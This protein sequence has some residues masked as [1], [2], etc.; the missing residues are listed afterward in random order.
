VEKLR[1]YY[2]D[3]LDLIC[4]DCRRRYDI[5][6]LR[7]LDCKHDSCQPF[8]AAAPRLIDNLCEPCT[9]HFTQVR[10]LLGELGIAYTIEPLLVRGLDYYART[11][12]E[13][14]PPIESSQSALGGGGRY[15]GLVEQLG[16]PSTPAM[17]FGTGIE[18]IILNLKR[19]EIRPPEMARIDA[20]I[21]VADEAAAGYAMRAARELRDAADATVV[22]GSAGRSLRAQL[23]QAGSLNA[24]FAVIIGAREREAG[25]VTLRDLS[26]GEETQLTIDQAAERIR[27]ASTP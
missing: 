23:R 9:D 24:R 8:K 7:L 11:T 10:L 20:L 14:Q 18:R 17:G 12:F 5:N 4:A 25:L 22:V 13:F 21:A 19:R 6:P 15:D 16:G 27:T 1:S 2:S 3:K 26:L